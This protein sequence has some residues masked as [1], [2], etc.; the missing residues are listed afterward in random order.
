MR[1]KEARNLIQEGFLG[2][3]L[4][5]KLA[6][7]LK[8]TIEPDQARAIIR[9]RLEQREDDFIEIA[10][11]CIYAQPQ[12]PY[13]RL[14]KHAG[15][16]YGDFESLIHK[17]GL[18]GALHNL[19]RQG[20]Y[21]TSKEF[22]GDCETVRGNTRIVVTPKKLQNPFAK[23][24]IPI[25][26]SGSRSH[27]TQIVRSLDFIHDTT[28][29]LV[30]YLEARQNSARSELATWSVPGAVILSSFIKFI[31]AGS[32]PS[33]WFSQL[34][35]KAHELSIRYRLSTHVLEWGGTLAGIPIPHPEYVSL[36]DPSPIIQWMTD[37]LQRE[38]TPH[39]FTYTSAA[40]R[41]A[42]CALKADIDLQGV[43]ITMSGEPTTPARLE[44]IK[45][46]GVNALPAMG[47]VEVGHIGYGC[48]TPEA[49]DD[50]HLLKDLHAVIQPGESNDSP[51][52]RT[53]AL[54]F[55]TLRLSSPLILLNVSLGDEAKLKRRPCGC[56]QGE[57]GMNT[58]IQYVRSFE[59]LTSGGMAFLDTE[60]IHVI[61]DELPKMFGGGPTD[62]QLLEDE[63]DDGKP[64][65]RLIIHP[66]VGSLDL[67]KVKEIFL[68]K[69]ASGSGAEKLTSLV[70]QNA[71]MVTVE[72]GTPKTTSTGKI[73][74]MHIEQH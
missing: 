29:Y 30:L 11:K 2:I 64:Q 34:D 25:R 47:C 49:P 73:Q 12:S 52:L 10:K 26:S 39:L 74:H 55:S 28:I 23:R 40:V 6:S 58:H 36:D 1:I 16:E 35:A 70:W 51:D 65:L 8:K 59:K 7:T 43:Q 62:Y 9:Q 31:L 37:C 45:R 60:I 18:E 54:L 3:R 41:L 69:I 48:L 14:L 53:H 46:S 38:Q 22:R 42:Q 4:V 24:H 44:S 63:R 72:R 13:L 20:V 32:P 71:E 17:E 21:L 50:M 19:F 33:H 15:C 68:Q 66:R 57:L 5:G 61:E 56:F 67:D 27:G